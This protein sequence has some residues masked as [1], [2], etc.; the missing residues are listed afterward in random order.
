MPAYSS[1]EKRMGRTGS[2]VVA[3]ILGLLCAVFGLR[4]L[5]LIVTGGLSAAAGRI[6]PQALLA[7]ICGW[8]AYKLVLQARAR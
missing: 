4:A 6:I 5:E 7:I 1:E 8:G 3:G 2:Y